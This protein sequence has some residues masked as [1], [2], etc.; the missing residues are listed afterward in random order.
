MPPFVIL[1]SMLCSQIRKLRPGNNCPSFN[2]IN[3]ISP[4]SQDTRT[5]AN[6]ATITTTEIVANLINY[7]VEL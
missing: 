5:A 6:A 4:G 7:E 1:S 2:Y 3:I